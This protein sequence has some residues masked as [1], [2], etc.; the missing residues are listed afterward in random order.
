MMDFLKRSARLCTLAALAFPAAAQ[1]AITRGIPPKVHWPVDEWLTVTVEAKSQYVSRI[2]EGDAEKGMG[3]LAY[4]WY[5]GPAECLKRADMSPCRL[6]GQTSDTLAME[7]LANGGGEYW[8]EVTDTA[9]HRK[10]LEGPMLL[11]PCFRVDAKGAKVS[12]L[13]GGLASLVPVET[14]YER[15]RQLEEARL[16]GSRSKVI[17]GLSAVHPGSGLPVGRATWA[18]GPAPSAVRTEFKAMAVSAAMEPLFLGGYDDMP[19][20][21]DLPGELEPH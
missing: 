4:Q 17:Q 10:V 18:S 11:V 12:Q 16:A 21:E 1:P 13:A 19:P 8:V 6:D 2:P 20:L 7:C 5:K 3:T 14:Y 9:D 15:Q